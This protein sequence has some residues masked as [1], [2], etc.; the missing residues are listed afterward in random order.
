LTISSA[1][2]ESWGAINETDSATCQ[3][4]FASVQWPAF[5]GQRNPITKKAGDSKFGTASFQIHGNRSI[6][7]IDAN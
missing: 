1:L 7:P 3:S 2:A 5:S 4:F 6:N